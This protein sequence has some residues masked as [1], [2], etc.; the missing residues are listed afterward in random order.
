MPKLFQLSLSSFPHIQWALNLL[1]PIECPRDKDI[2]P[3]EKETDV[4][5]SC[6]NQGNK[7]S[8]FD[9]TDDDVVNED[10]V[11]DQEKDSPSVEMSKRPMQQATLEARKKISQWLNPQTA[12]VWGVSQSL[13]R[14]NDIIAKYSIDSIYNCNSN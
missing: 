14:N 11:V 7:S 2:E 13:L 12:F 9:D 8:L 3:G 4:N 1:Y 6:N 5:T 10:D